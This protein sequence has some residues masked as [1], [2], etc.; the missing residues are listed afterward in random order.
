MDK[1]GKGNGKGG[2]RNVEEVLVTG[3]GKRERGPERRHRA[4]GGN[5]LITFS[6]VMQEVMNRIE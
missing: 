2:Q 6:M 4:D 3:E 5:I 1:I